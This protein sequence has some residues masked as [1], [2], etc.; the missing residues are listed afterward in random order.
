VRLIDNIYQLAAV[1]ALTWGDLKERLTRLTRV[2]EILLSL[3]LQKDESFSQAQ[4]HYKQDSQ[5]FW[6]LDS[7]IAN[8]VQGASTI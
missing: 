1:D 3:I 7:S 4:R 8:R 5:S 6:N 2:A